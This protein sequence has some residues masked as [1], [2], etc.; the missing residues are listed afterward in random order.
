MSN[1]EIKYNS[2]DSD[3]QGNNFPAF[4]IKH[5]GIE[6]KHIVE[7]EMPLIIALHTQHEIHE[8]ELAFMQHMQLPIEQ[9][10]A[11]FFSDRVKIWN[12]FPPVSCQAKADS[13]VMYADIK[14]WSKL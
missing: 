12:S 4:F 11:C 10:Y 5:N 14:N 3:T 1:T 2:L 9:P 8:N 13:E 6:V 7:E